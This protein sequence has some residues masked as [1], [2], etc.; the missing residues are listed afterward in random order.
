MKESGEEAEK[1]ILKYKKILNA[2]K[3]KM[4]DEEVIASIMMEYPKEEDKTRE[5][6][7]KIVRENAHYRAQRKSTER[8]LFEE[9]REYILSDKSMDLTIVLDNRTL[10]VDNMIAVGRYIAKW[11]AQRKRE[12]TLED[13]RVEIWRK[14]LITS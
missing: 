11:Q 13:G 3:E 7:K 10:Q 9:D 5:G 4:V 2:V 1:A 8:N 14:M 12:T 6:E